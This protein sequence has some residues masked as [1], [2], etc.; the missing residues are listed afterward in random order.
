M[1]S[2]GIK[3]GWC[4]YASIRPAKKIFCFNNAVR[5]CIILGKSSGDECL[6]APDPGPEDEILQTLLKVLNARAEKPTKN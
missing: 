1:F 2:S 4:Y 5:T 3:V 6:D